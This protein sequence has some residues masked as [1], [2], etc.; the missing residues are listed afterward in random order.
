MD[1][2]DEY[3]KL[4]VDEIAYVR[5]RMGEAKSADKKVYYYSAIFGLLERV[6]RMDYDRQVLFI[7]FVF[8]STYNLIYS[9]IQAIKAGG[10]PIELDYPDFFANLDVGL[11]NLQSHMEKKQDNDIYGDLEYIVALAWTITGGGF[12]DKEKFDLP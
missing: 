7:H 9:Q 6:M 3:R 1:I 12:Y 2:S 5:K 10:I 8:N 11:A 4:V